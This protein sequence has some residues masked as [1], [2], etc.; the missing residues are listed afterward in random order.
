MTVRKSWA[1]AAALVLVVATSPLANA[2]TI[3]HEWKFED[4]L[5]DTSGSGNDG[6]ATGAPSYIGG[7]FGAAIT[8]AAGESVDNLA[9]TNIPVGAGDAFSL[10]LWYKRDSAAVSKSYFGGIG[11]R[12][13]GG[14]SNRAIYSFGTGGNP[15]NNIY[16]YSHSGDI[17]TATPFSADDKWHM[18]TVTGATT[19]NAGELKL[20]VYHDSIWIDGDTKSLN[21]VVAQVGVGGDIAALSGSYDLGG[22]DEFT[23]WEGAL[24]QA[25]IDTLFATNTVESVP[26]PSTILL[27]GLALTMLSAGRRR[28]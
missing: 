1:F 17:S 2:A 18:I 28:F 12:G 8:I 9:P 14:Q 22:I 11:D 4:N 24:S 23:V 20:D 21:G 16:F 3:V 10:N 19:A 13:T 7:K 6:T 25:N 5:L 15:S 27:T 26:E